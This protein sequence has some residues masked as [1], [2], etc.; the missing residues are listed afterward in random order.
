MPLYGV[1]QAGGVLSAIYPGNS[2]V[3]FNGTETPSAG[4]K[5]VAF[6]RALGNGAQAQ[7]VFT[8]TFPASP[9]A[10]VVIQGSN[11]DV[12]AHYQT[13]SGNITTQTGYYA[14]LGEFAFY[15]ANLSAYASGGMPT[16]I[17]QR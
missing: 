13:L 6:S 9:T 16:V 1:A 17:V 11:D 2:F 14:D 7:Q 10:T 8:V 3:L 12:E 15:R 4:L 5:S